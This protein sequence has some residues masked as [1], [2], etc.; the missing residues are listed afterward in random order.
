MMTHIIQAIEKWSKETPDHI[1]F[2]GHDETGELLSISYQQ[3]EAR[4]HAVAKQLKAADATAIA[5][6][7]DNRLNWV[8]VDLAAMYSGIVVIPVPTFFSESQVQ[9]ILQ[10]SAA[11]ILIGEWAD[12]EGHYVGKQLGTMAGL[13]AYQHLT[14]ATKAYLPGTQ[15]ITFTSG[16]T[17]APK[18]V[19]LSAD[20]ID[21]VSL[22]L[23]DSITGQASRHLILLP[24]S[25][26][27]E[28]ITGVYVP[29]L[30]GATSYVVSGEH[31][32]L[33]GSNQFDI[34][35]F[36]IALTQYRPHSL[37]LTPA[38][39]IALLSLVKQFP[40]LAQ[41]L[42]FVA[43]GGARVS[44]SLMAAAW[45]LGIPAYEGYGLSECGS[46]VCLNTPIQNK[47]GTSGCVLPHIQARI[48]K[49]GELEVKGNN[50]LGYLG[51]PFTETWLATGDLAQVDDDGFIT[52]MGRKKNLIVT[53]YGRNVSPE[54]I[55]S[56]AF[57]YLQT[58]PFFV[59][60]NDLHSLCAVTQQCSDLQHKVSV[61]NELLPD[62]AR[63]GC[64]LVLDNIQG[65]TPWFTA[66]GKIRRNLLEQDVTRFLMDPSQTQLHGQPVTRINVNSELTTSS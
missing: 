41:T 49:D 53:A 57:T 10:S 65:I 3:L 43:V 31:T 25:T 39:L 35:R 20:N 51:E 16:S 32:G 60:G 29:L 56:E 48:A 63:I 8:I 22:S 34:S 36:M 62:Y 5:L 14:S 6:R 38:L 12:D 33:M 42:T 61:L 9:H 24:L 27:L 66:N 18:G 7:A 40:E 59:V 23:A 4:V 64:L 2:V 30:L 52:L 37:V 26:L 58:L 50:A 47:A 46:V 54:W 55:E 1:A 17:G 15:K 11:D 19:C 45:Q 28:N 21:R 44:A 13:N